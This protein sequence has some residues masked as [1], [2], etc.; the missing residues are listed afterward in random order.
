MQYLGHLLNLT[1]LATCLLSFKYYNLLKAQELDLSHLW[2]PLQLCLPD[3]W[4]HRLNIIGF[5]GGKN[6]FSF[7]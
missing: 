3:F 7:W 6:N 5:F 1:I 4:I 2:N